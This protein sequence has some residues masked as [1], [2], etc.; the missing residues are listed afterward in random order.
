MNVEKELKEV[1]KRMLD[2]REDLSRVI[3]MFD[4]IVKR[5]ENLE[6]TL[7]SLN[8]QNINKLNGE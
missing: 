7:A 2:I 1:Y 5:V 4:A 3:N 6:A 8:S